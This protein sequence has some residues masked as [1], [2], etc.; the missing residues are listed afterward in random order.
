MIFFGDNFLFQS[1]KSETHIIRLEIAVLKPKKALL[2]F[3]CERG[4]K[5]RG[6]EDCRDKQ[7]KMECGT[8]RPSGV[9]IVVLLMEH[10]LIYKV[11]LTK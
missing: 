11:L 9:L 1:P 10:L 8:I 2:V 7:K 4:E 6:R 5:G 3:G